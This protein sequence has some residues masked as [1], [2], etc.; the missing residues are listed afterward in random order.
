LA[1][2]LVLDFD[3]TVTDAEA[4]GAPFRAGYLEDLAT[5]T[6]LD[7]GLVEALAVRFA[8]EVDAAADREGWVFLGR[9]VAPATVDP[10]LRMMPVARRILDYAGAFLNEA[11]RTRLLDGI[12]YKY[13]YQKTHIA[14]RPAARD[15]LLALQP[16]PLW[17]VTNSHTEAV[18]AKIRALGVRP[19]GGN[20]LL[21]LSERVIGRAR[22]YMLD[23]SW[24]DVPESMSLP[25][26]ARP[27]LLRRRAYYE[28]LDRLRLAA[29][30]EWADITVVG[31]IFELDLALPLAAGARVGLLA[32]AH[33]PAWERAYLRDHPRGAV[34]LDLAEVPAYF[35]AG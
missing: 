29:G 12:L 32:N 19:D 13:N 35:Y 21:P 2:L 6:G 23:D 22:K 33:T 14:F 10:Y 5:L 26:L 20:D 24:V 11:D 16:E 7:F 15:V 28:V 17:V 34:L 3:G 31:D 1:R 30:A 25:G 18:Q 9:V 8:A 27:V 4:E